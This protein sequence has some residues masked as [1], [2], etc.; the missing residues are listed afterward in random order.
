MFLGSIPV[1]GDANDFIAYATGC[2]IIEAI[3]GLG[4]EERGIYLAAALGPFVGG[5][6]L[7]NLA[8][9]ADIIKAE[10]SASSRILRRN[11]IEAGYAAQPGSVTHH[12]VAGADRRAANARAILQRYG[13]GIDD[14]ENGVFLPGT[15]HAGVH[16]DTYYQRV[17]AL[18][19]NATSREEVIAV[20]N[21]IRYQLQTGGFSK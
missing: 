1:I 21:D 8:N 6:T 4:P 13:I 20:L 3:C 14:A 9:A 15:V 11:L 5:K 17:D 2:S 12:M 10:R 7:K 18:L 16:G 19:T